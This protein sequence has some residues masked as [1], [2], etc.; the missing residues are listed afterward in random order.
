MAKVKRE[1][2]M[3]ANI[4]TVEHD[5][6][7]DF[8]KYAQEIFVTVL[9]NPLR[10][11]YHEH[12]EEYLGVCN[13]EKCCGHFLGVTQ[14]AGDVP[15]ESNI[16]VSEVVQ[17]PADGEQVLLTLSYLPCDEMVYDDLPHHFPLN[18]LDEDIN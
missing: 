7:E 10:I 13:S 8:L 18:V 11:S 2:K 12:V 1:L 14:F 15:V 6:L 4:I 3:E 16:A 5:E 9:V 17:D